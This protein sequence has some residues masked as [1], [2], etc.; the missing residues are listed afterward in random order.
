MQACDFPGS[1][2]I[3]APRDWNHELDGAC[4]A[5]FVLDS[6]DTLSGMNFMY[7]VYKPTDE[8]IEELKNGGVIRL[9]I[10]GHSH[11]V[12]QLG[13]LSAALARTVELEPKWDLGPVIS[14]DNK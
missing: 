14:G 1:R 5:I 13:V 12:F 8:E 4:G 11:P 2:R 3:G 9:G 6:I 10:M 7:S